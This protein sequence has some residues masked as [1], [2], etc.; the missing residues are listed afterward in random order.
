[1]KTIIVT[2]ATGFIG[3]SLLPALQQQGYRV[4]AAVRNP[5]V[6]Q[7]PLG[8]DVVMVGDLSPTTE[9][10]A[11]LKDV[12]GVIHL[13]ARRGNVLAGTSPE[14]DLE[15]QRINV[16]GTTNLVKQAIAAETKHFVFISSI[17]AMATLGNISLTEDSQC[18][19]DTPY[20]H[21]KLLAE[22]A[23]RE[24]AGSSSMAWTILR[25]PLVY[26]AGNPGSMKRLLK[27][28][29]SGLPLPFAAIDNRRSLIFV[30][31][32]VD[33]LLCCLANPVAAGQTFLVSDGEDI[34]TPELMRCMAIALHC[35]HHL[36]PIPPA[37]LR[38]LGQLTGKST[39]VRR[40]LGS[41]TIDSSKIRHILNWEP[42]YTLA[43]GLQ[44]TAD[45]YLQSHA[46]T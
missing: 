44:E 20:G 19:P 4:K 25:P 35:P 30:K 11:A 9:W 38:I 18:C 17:G 27:L 22:Q 26:G 37:G 46:K 16:A 41:L 31:N 40:L 23:V 43:Q 32:L 21:S 13:A 10:Q 8:V 7:L 42:P 33:A 12:D 14:A 28:V 36:F 2:G 5:Q 6:S 45:W 24:L 15:F 39:A 1:M 34:S 3:R 29:Y